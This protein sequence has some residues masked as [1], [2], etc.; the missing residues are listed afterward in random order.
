MTLAT[1]AL[2]ALHHRGA[3]AQNRPAVLQSVDLRIPTPPVTVRVDGTTRLVYELHLTN[4][5][6]V[7]VSIVRLQV[8]GAGSQAV[9]EYQGEPLR[10]MVGRPGMPR[11]EL[12]QAAIGPGAR[13]IVY[14][15]IA[16][17][18]GAAPATLRHRVEVDVQRATGPVRVT[19][20]SAPIAVS[21]NAATLID[22]PLRGGPW[23]AAY[24]PQLVGGHR[25]VFY[26]ID[27]RA[28][29]PGRF[30]IDWIR[31]T[32]DGTLDRTQPRPADWNGLGSEVLAVADGIVVSA[33]DD[34]P[35][36]TGAPGAP[37]HPLENASGNY[38][39]IDIGRGRFAFYE[40]LQHGSVN[41]R[42]GDRVRRGRVIARLGNSGS[43]SVGP[44]L[45]FHLSDANSD[46]G[47]EGMPFVFRVFEH[48]GAFSSIQALHE[49]ERFVADSTIHGVHRTLERPGANAVVR[50]P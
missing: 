28:R 19:F 41:V 26:T 46:L 35:D 9:A 16:L 8:L 37:P 3:A 44:H 29:I 34:I 22:P 25:T 18:E 1:L 15:W 7:E 14:F 38:V 48:L 45:H 12:P 36:N 33:M 30:A 23:V 43:S 40:H 6:P 39:A 27:G 42:V 4:L 32:P 20:E 2:V 17:A 21:A 47:A 13:T 11:S 50:F 31:V 24:D 5:L 49:G 10:R